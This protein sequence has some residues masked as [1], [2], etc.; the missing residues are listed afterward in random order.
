MEKTTLQIV[1]ELVERFTTHR[2]AYLSSEYNETQVRREFIDPL[3]KALGWDVDN[4]QGNAEQWK[5]VI[6]ED[7]I[8]IGGFTKAPDYSFRLGGR[9]LFFL[10]AKKPAV[11]IKDDPGPAFQLRRY[12]WTAKLPVSILTDFEEFI[13]YDTRIQPV[14]TDKPSK[15][16]I[17]VIR[18]EEYVDR[19]DEIAS[20]FS[21]EAIRK[22]AFDKYIETATQ[23]RGTATVDDAFLAEIE[24]WREQLARNIA[25]RNSGVTQ[26][27]LNFAVQCII[28]RIVFL[29]ICEDRGIEDYGRLQALLNGTNIYA[30]LRELFYSADERY[31]SGLFHFHKEKDREGAPDELTPRLQID[32]KV[33]KDIFRRLYY[34]DC[35]YEFSVLPTEILG[36][37]YERFLGSVIR[38]TAGGHAKVEQKP[39]V[40]KAGGVYYTPT[41]IV[42]YIVKHT[43]GKL[44]EGKT[45]QEI[46][47][48]TDAWR[49]S[50]NR[51]PLAILD[52]ACGS[53]SFLLGAYQ[54]LLDWHLEQYSKD[55]DKW[56]K[57]KEPKLFRD[58]RGVWRLTTVERKRILLSNI[59]GVDID[60]QAVEVTKLSLL[61]K[62]LEG[63][64]AE[65]MR[66][67]LAIFHERALPDLGANIKCGNSLIGPD[68]YEGRQSGLFDEEEM[69]RV[70]A[71]DWSAEFAEIMKRG[72]FDAVIG[73]PPYVR[74]EMFKDVKQYLRDHFQSHDERTDLYVYFIEKEHDLLCEK[75]RFG[76]IVS[77]KFIRA[78]YGEPLRRHL[79]SVSTIERI[80]DLAGLPVF[81]GATVRTVVLISHKRRTGEVSPLVI[82]SPPPTKEELAHVEISTS[83]LSDIADPSAY[84]VPTENLMASG[85]RLIRPEASA[86]MNRL[87]EKGASLRDLTSD[88]I[89][90]GIKSGLTE[91]FIINAQKRDE[92]IAKNPE[93]RNIIHPFLQGRQIFRYGIE[94]TNDYVI[95]THHGIDMNPY[96]AV[97]DH[98]QPFRKS[99]EGRATKQAWYELQQPQFGYVEY[100]NQPKVIFPDISPECRFALDTENHFVSNTVYFIPITD[101]IPLLGLLNSRVA[102]FFFKQTCAALEGPGEAYLRFFGQYLEGFPVC[103]PASGDPTHQHLVELVRIMLDLHKQLTSATT[104]HGRTV[105]R[106]QV[107]ETDSEINRL[108]YRLYELTEE[109]IRIVEEATELK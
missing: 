32:D 30:R 77:N 34:P 5:E 69:Y 11:N 25:V 91:A 89:C 52:P 95:Y 108:V 9:R 19:W 85:W 87:Q 66:K 41:Y 38:L 42:D 3:F 103:M 2:D 105:V 49:P 44:L 57:G 83:T 47:G 54:L 73:N 70:N 96:P 10:E 101:C 88:R 7:A 31:N 18:H 36:Q 26:R 23:K 22:G 24:D 53:G 33:L 102:F 45:P 109:E 74:M 60:A 6:H 13:V 1:R 76:M 79:S 93:A 29:R 28:D 8:K 37:V 67:Q 48:V 58:H 81:R 80:I 99:L 20:I 43:V 27:E 12:A 4:E 97:I 46:A 62:V 100:L 107:A 55:L 82:Y 39:D 78:N 61:L 16:R 68:F 59:F 15:A 65:T 64:N 92:I 86:L 35:P 98:L 63:E 17:L 104:D 21:P 51:H 14:I 50:A 56:S 71:F 84:D 94:P 72:G 90:M 106:R 40:R 75:G